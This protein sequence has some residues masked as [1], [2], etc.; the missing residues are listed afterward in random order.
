MGHDNASALQ[1]SSWTPSTAQMALLRNEFHPYSLHWGVLILVGRDMVISIHLWIEIHLHPF[2]SLPHWV[3]PYG[4]VRLA[5]VRPLQVPL[6]D[7]RPTMHFFCLLSSQLPIAC[8]TVASATFS[9][10]LLTTDNLNNYITDEWLQDHD[11]AFKIWCRLQQSQLRASYPRQL[12]A[13]NLLVLRGIGGFPT[14]RRRWECP[15][16]MSATRSNHTYEV[17][18]LRE[19]TCRTF[20]LKWWR[21]FTLNVDGSFAK[22][23]AH[24]RRSTSSA[25]WIPNIG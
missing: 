16:A 23:S 4:V 25:H 15:E 13:Q 18:I 10:L 20:L 6:M 3:F 24:T 11:H 5:L 1:L 12:A 19:P 2:F 7:T 22:H 8:A 14:S 21:L 17:N 9:Q